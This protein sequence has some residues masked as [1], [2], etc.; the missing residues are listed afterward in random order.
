[1]ENL[2]EAQTIIGN[3]NF[4]T[5]NK[6]LLWIFLRQSM[7]KSC[8]RERFISWINLDFGQ[9]APVDEVFLGGVQHP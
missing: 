6:P 3:W 9:D 7:G 8:L 4:E 5:R 1:M 2:I